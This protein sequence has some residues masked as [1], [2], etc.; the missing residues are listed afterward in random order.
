MQSFVAR[1]LINGPL[2]VGVEESE[3]T[4]FG[5]FSAEITGRRHAFI[6]LR[7]HADAGVLRRQAKRYTHCIIA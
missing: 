1:E 6:A 7:Y 5:E 3:I 2:I 4:T